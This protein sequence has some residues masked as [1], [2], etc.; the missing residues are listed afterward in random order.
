MDGTP[1]I[2]WTSERSLRV[3]GPPPVVVAQMLRGLPGVLDAVPTEVATFV[4]LD[5]LAGVTTPSIE[6]RLAGF[7]AWT[8]PEPRRHEIPVCYE[9]PFARDLAE[10]ARLVGVSES[11]VI[12]LHTSTEFTVAFMGFA[13]GF[14]YLTGLPRGFRVPRLGSPR[15]K[16]EAGSVGLGGAY[17]GVYPMDGPGGWR[18]IGRTNTRLF[19][20]HREPAALLRAGDV[21]RFRSV[22]AWELRL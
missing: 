1:Q 12:G 9:P 16:L 15:A 10:V 22:S 14:G 17:S 13:P 8:P 4:T 7:D 11:G 18:V 19:D 6:R 2:S 21:V 20:P 5:P 3:D